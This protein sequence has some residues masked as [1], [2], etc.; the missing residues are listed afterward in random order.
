MYQHLIKQS[1]PHS[2]TAVQFVGMD[3]QWSAFSEQTENFQSS[4]APLLA[5][6]SHA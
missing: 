1:E 2:K 3:G 5:E 6:A 4:I